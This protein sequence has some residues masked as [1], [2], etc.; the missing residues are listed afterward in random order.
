VWNKTKPWVAG[1]REELK[2]P[3]MFRNLEAIAEDTVQ[4][5]TRQQEKS[6]ER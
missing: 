5:Q 4:W 3:L 6:Q 2:N 1:V